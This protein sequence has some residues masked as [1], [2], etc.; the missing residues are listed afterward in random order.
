MASALTVVPYERRYRSAT[1]DLIDYSFQRHTHLDWYEPDEWLDN[2]A[3]V[4]Q[5]AFRG[6]HLVGMLATTMPMGGTAWLRLVAIADGAPEAQVLERLWLPTADALRAAGAESVWALILEPWLEYFTPLFG[7]QEAERLVTLRREGD[8]LPVLPD[9]PEIV[10]EQ[11]TMDDVGAMAAVD[12]AAFSPPYQMTAQEM[13]RAY[14]FAAM[15]TVARLD[16]RLIGYQLSTKHGEQGHLARLAVEPSLQGRGIGA[17]LVRDLTAAFLRRHVE[18][19]TVNTQMT[20]ARSL[21]LYASCGFE[22]AGF[23]LPIY[24][25]TLTPAEAQRGGEE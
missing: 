8:A 22:R 25:A 16:G 24:K 3:S 19:I 10:I 5:L 14:R 7:M 23:D 11:A 13:R 4:V 12:Q 2:V 15:S 17:L 21:Q 1:V 20:N 9:Q 6:T 18:H